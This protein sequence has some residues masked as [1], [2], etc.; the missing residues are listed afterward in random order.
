VGIQYPEPTPA[1]GTPRHRV[2]DRDHV[3]RGDGS[4]LDMDLDGAH[5]M[6][7]LGS[8]R[9]D[10]SRLPVIFLT[11]K[12]EEVDELMGLRLGADDYITKP[13]NMKILLARLRTVLAR[14]RSAATPG[15]AWPTR[16][17]AASTSSRRDALL[18][19]EW[20]IHGEGLARRDKE[21]SARRGPR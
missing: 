1:P 21:A 3:T 11:S 4:I 12:D 19:G 7:L 5:I 2:A 14:D 8:K 17:R 9:V 20:P 15:R 16:C 10:G 13:F 18:L 6:E